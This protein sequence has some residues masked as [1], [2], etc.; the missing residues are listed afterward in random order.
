MFVILVQWEFGSNHVTRARQAAAAVS[1][2]KLS[3]ISSAACNVRPAAHALRFAYNR[4][5]VRTVRLPYLLV[6]VTTLAGGAPLH[7]PVNKRSRDSASSASTSASKCSSSDADA[8]LPVSAACL[9]AAN[10]SSYVAASVNIDRPCILS[11]IDA[12]TH[13]PAAAGGQPLTRSRL[14][15]NRL[16]DRS[17]F[18]A[19]SSNMQA[20]PN[21]TT[22]NLPL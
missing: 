3:C 4:G 7:L 13:R 18:K 15:C 14:F 20:A 16:R 12:C 10:P 19:I 5:A 9:G 6:L 22:P 21:N 8:P 11:I 1:P 2:L 17:S